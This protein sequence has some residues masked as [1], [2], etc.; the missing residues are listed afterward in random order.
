MEAV[1]GAVGLAGRAQVLPAQ[2]SSGERARA[3]LAVALINDPPVL[4][5]DEPTGEVDA[6]NEALLLDILVERA[7]QGGAN[8]IVT[9]SRAVASAATRVLHL[10]D[11]RLEDD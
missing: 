1:L 3:G 9:H 6:A 10:V 7:R 5:A 11:G 2:L 4:L 8:L